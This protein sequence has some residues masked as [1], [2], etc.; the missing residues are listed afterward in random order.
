V[1]QA[2]HVHIDPRDI[3]E[4]ARYVA[5]LSAWRSLLDGLV[6]TM[7]VL[8]V[9]DIADPGVDGVR[10]ASAALQP[11]KIRTALDHIECSS[12]VAHIEVY[13]ILGRRTLEIDLDCYSGGDRYPSWDVF[14]GDWRGGVFRTTVRKLYSVYEELSPPDIEALADAAGHLGEPV[15][16]AARAILG[17]VKK[18]VEAAAPRIKRLEAEDIEVK[19]V[20]DIERAA[21]EA[22]AQLVRAIEAIKS[23]GRGVEGELSKGVLVCGRDY[24]VE[25]LLNMYGE[26]SQ[27]PEGHRQRLER[28]KEDAKHILRRKAL[29]GLILWEEA[30]R[31]GFR[32]D[33]WSVAF[34]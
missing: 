15:A 26:Y 9:L 16:G 11:R 21:G 28:M 8:L 20:C 14:S 10:K 25:S 1:A 7:R 24:T 6:N 30:I 19:P 33:P 23:G 13:P 4:F 17:A 32:T 29:V 12:V 31:A 5:E 2:R 27:N 3:E 18:V 22:A 34:I